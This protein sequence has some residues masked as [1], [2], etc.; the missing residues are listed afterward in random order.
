MKYLFIITLLI[1]ISFNAIA[2]DVLKIKDQDPVG[3]TILENKSGK[4]SFI[5][6]GDTSLKVRTAP[7]FA[8]EY[9]KFNDTAFYNDTNNKIT[10]VAIPNNLVFDDI[11]LV[12]TEN[13]DTSSYLTQAGIIY[14]QTLN[15]K[16]IVF[17]LTGALVLVGT[18]AGI[19]V[20]NTIA[21]IIIL[22]STIYIYTQEYKFA[23]QLIDAGK[24]SR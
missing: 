16:L 3:V 1:V 5:I 6:Y 10:Y 22:T 15:T 2:Q 20:I 14:K 12:N 18:V 24:T 17:P 4:V 7:M 9:I 13:T 19:P 8:V 21:G 23:N 11:P